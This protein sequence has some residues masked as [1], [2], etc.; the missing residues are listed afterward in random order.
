MMDWNEMPNG[1]LDGLD[2]LLGNLCLAFM[3][4][5]WTEAEAGAPGA[6]ASLREQLEELRMEQEELGTSSVELEA[7]AAEME[8]ANEQLWVC[9]DGLENWLLQPTS[10]GLQGIEADVRRAEAWLQHAG[11]QAEDTEESL[12]LELSC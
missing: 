12:C 7:V 8:R 9:L 10:E 11:M 3:L 5:D 2:W 4:A 6:I 1:V